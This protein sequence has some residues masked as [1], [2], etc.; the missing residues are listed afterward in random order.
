MNAS[1][2]HVRVT[3]WL[4]RGVEGAPGGGTVVECWLPFEPGAPAPAS[5][6]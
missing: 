5:M 2:D 4:R 3:P 1:M 6:G